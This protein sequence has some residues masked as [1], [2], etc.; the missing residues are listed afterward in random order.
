MINKGICFTFDKNQII[1]INYVIP[2][3]FQKF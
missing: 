1:L 2:K 3:R